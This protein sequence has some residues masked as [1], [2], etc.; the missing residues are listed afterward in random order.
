MKKFI[1][2][3]I[4]IIILISVGVV[5]EVLVHNFVKEFEEKTFSISYD[6]E[7]ANE[8]INTEKIKAKLT[9]LEDYWKNKKTKFCYLVMYDKIKMID[10]G[11]AKLDISIK[12]N[13]KALAQE[14]IAVLLC[15]TDSLHYIMGFNINNLF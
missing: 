2:I 1:S 15:Y 9:S 11:V 12:S 6:L 10:E 4:I 8:N 5:E 14:N 13:D 7:E 3:L